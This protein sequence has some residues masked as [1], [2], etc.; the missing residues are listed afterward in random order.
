[1]DGRC[2]VRADHPR[3]SKGCEDYQDYYLAGEIHDAKIHDAKIHDAIYSFHSPAKKVS[4]RE[5]KRVLGYLIIFFIFASI[6]VFGVMVIH[7]PF[8][9]LLGIYCFALGTVGLIFLAV[10]WIMGG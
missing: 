1:L 9:V 10:T 2:G 7:I 3:T 6:F 8:L 4:A 5:I